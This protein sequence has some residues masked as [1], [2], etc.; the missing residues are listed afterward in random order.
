MLHAS[1]EEA[2]R[3]GEPPTEPE[4]QPYIDWV[5][6]LKGHTWLEQRVYYGVVLG[7]ADEIAFGTADCINLSAD[8][9]TITIGDLKTGAM[10]VDP[11]GNPQL[12]LY[13]LGAFKFFD[14]I[15]YDVSL[16]ERVNMVIIQPRI[17]EQ[18]QVWEADVFDLQRMQVSLGDAAGTAVTYRGRTDDPLLPLVPGEDACRWCPAAA[19]CPRLASVVEKFQHPAMPA[20]KAS[21]F[22]AVV[23]ASKALTDHYKA[24]PL[25]RIW[26]DA[27]EEA[28]SSATAR[29]EETG[30]KFVEGR[31]GNRRWADENAVA[32]ALKRSGLDRSEYLQPSKIVSPAQFDKVLKQHPD[33]K[34][35]VE[36]LIERPQGK[37]TLVPESDPRPKWVEDRAAK[38]LDTFKAL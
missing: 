35:V 21:D 12:A 30:Y 27:I 22:K 2:L 26:C 37:P 14:L 4:I 20:A 34:A 1:A 19:T 7:V 28:L 36:P 13:A 31:L 9:R 8:E 38:V 3:K 15:G 25:L 29:G 33:M 18:P 23:P 32:N 24:V 11:V 5:K 6:S 17:S 16:I 10:H